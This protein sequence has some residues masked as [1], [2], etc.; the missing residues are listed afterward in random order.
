MSTEVRPVSLDQIRA[1]RDRIDGVA[2]RSPI[3]RSTLS[4]EGDD[5]HVKLESLQPIGSFKI[6]PCASVILSRPAE[7]LNLGVYTASSGNSA[8]G[9]AWMARKLGILATALVLE[10][11]SREKLAALR[12]LRADLR[13]LPFDQWW[14]V[15]MGATKPDTKAL[16]VDAVR[17]PLALAG[18]GTIGLE[19]AEQ[20][21]EVDAVFVPFGGGGLI[22]GI[23]CALSA[24]RPD[25][26]VV[27]CELE[28]AAPLSAAFRAGKPVEVRAETGFVSGVGVRSVLPEMWPLISQVVDEVVTVPI[29]AVAATIEGLVRRDH[30]V[31]EGAGALSVAA[32]IH[33]RHTYRRVCAI[34]SGGNIEMR[35]LTKIL[36]GEEP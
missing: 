20:L 9:I 4:P 14:S 18:D 17:D 21:D 6:R 23:G 31:V 10:N 36:A 26:R 16:Y 11:A 12:A 13:V 2:V 34:A 29:A 28:S 3:I 27:A 24:L 8:I 32:A 5:V 19:V 30:I 35:H 1:A 25:V 7:S 15:V 33:G 22:G